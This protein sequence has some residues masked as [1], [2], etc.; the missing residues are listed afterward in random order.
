MMDTAAGVLGPVETTETFQALS[1]V[2]VLA[3]LL[4]LPTRTKQA[5]V[6]GV[7]RATP[8]TR[9]KFSAT[10]GTPAAAHGRA[11]PMETFQ[12]IH[13]LLVLARLLRLPTRTN[14]ALVLSPATPETR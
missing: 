13:A 3:R 11:W 1:A 2:Q 9:W 7:Y 4:R 5:L 14:Q 6:M 8:E 12:A 10:T